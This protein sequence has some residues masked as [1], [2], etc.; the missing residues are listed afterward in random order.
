MA[1]VAITQA[2]SAPPTPAAE[3][4]CSRLR[5][6]DRSLLS[7]LLTDI[8]FTDTCVAAALDVCTNAGQGQDSRNAYL[9]EVRLSPAAC[10][11][12]SQ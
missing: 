9:M 12:V 3:T 1:V 8:G 5:D 6:D 7:T 4:N 11:S 2:S 10:L